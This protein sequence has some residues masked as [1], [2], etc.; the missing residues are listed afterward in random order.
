MGLELHGQDGYSHVRYGPNPKPL[1]SL[2]N[3]TCHSTRPWFSKTGST[4]VALVISGK[5][6]AGSHAPPSTTPS[7]HG[8]V[9]VR[10]SIGLW[11]NA[12]A[13]ERPIKDRNGS[14]EGSV[15]RNG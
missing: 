12:G 2:S 5:L 1:F 13:V 8:G 3:V 14:F 6:L 7:P 10:T 9:S 11:E 4:L 15:D